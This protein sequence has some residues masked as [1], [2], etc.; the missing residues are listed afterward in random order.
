MKDKLP[1]EIKWRGSTY[2]LERV[3]NDQVFWINPVSRHHESCTVENW[4]NSEPYDR[5][6]GSF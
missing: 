2:V 5:P 4:K 3:E 1:D 6:I